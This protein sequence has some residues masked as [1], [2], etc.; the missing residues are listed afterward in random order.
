MRQVFDTI[1]ATLPPLQGIIHAAGVIDDGIIQQQNQQRF[2][3]VMRPKVQGAWNLHMLT[4]DR[5]LDFFVLFSSGASLLGSAG[6]ANYTAANTFLDVLAHWR[7]AQ[8]L[9]ALSINWGPW[10]K[11]LA[12][13]DQVAQR[14]SKKGITPITPA[15]GG[16]ILELLLLHSTVQVGV[17][18]INWSQYL[19][20]ST[21]SPFFTAFRPASDEQSQPQQSEFQ[22]QLKEATDPHALLQEHISRQVALVLRIDAAKS[23]DPELGFFE[24]GMDSLISVELRNRLQTSLGRPLPSTAAFDYPT[25]KSLTEFLLQGVATN[26]KQTVGEPETPLQEENIVIDEDEDVEEIAK[27]FAKQLGLEWEEIDEQ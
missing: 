24:M 1:D 6:Q 4:K 8:G 23:I 13:Q 11:G 18:P 3:Q 2:E 5:P 19:N 17:L 27:R 20:G 7:K 14:W 21:P 12:M 10:T 22:Q 9:P 15:Q 26:G 25:I 16:Q